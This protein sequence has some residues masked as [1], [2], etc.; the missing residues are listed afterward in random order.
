MP[1]TVVDEQRGRLV[2]S[3]GHLQAL[4]TGGA[5]AV[6]DDLRADG[7]RVGDGVSEALEAIAETL[8]HPLAMIELRMRRDGRVLEMT[9]A[10]DEALAVLTMPVEPGSD[11]VQVVAAPP[12]RIPRIVSAIVGLGERRYT[13]A[14]KCEPI[15]LDKRQLS[16]IATDEARTLRAQLPSSV[17]AGIAE[18]LTGPETA[19]WTVISKGTEALDGTMDQQVDVV[20]LGN[21]GLLII[22]ALPPDGAEFAAVP[23]TPGVIWRLLGALTAV[24]PADDAGEVA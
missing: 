13:A 23:A 21:A 3:A 19:R 2:L 20:D 6:L 15:V 16:Q 22:T 17:P 9:G 5:D 1:E 12:G 10:L 24:R 4:A 11:S 8:A 18:T 14:P 7:M